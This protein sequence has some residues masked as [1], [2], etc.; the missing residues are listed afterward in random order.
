MLLKLLGSILVM[1]ASTY[2]GF[3][4]SR[5]CAARPIQ[6]R[7]LQSLLQMLENEISYLSSVLTEAFEKIG[8]STNS[9]IGLFFSEAAAMLTN[10]TGLTAAQAWEQAVE[11]KLGRTALN[12]EDGEMLK[13]FGKLLGS[14]DREGQIKNIRLTAD[15]MKL[16]EQKAEESRRRNEKMYRSLGVL[17]GLAIVIILM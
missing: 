7:T 4:L 14:S 9:E 16:Q 3:T 13:A 2:L 11:N 17:G 8:K 6:L 12:R 1:A 15:H 5:E 10:G